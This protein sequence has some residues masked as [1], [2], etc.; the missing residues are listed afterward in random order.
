[1][2][3][4][5]FSCSLLEKNY[6]GRYL[7]RYQELYYLET[8]WTVRELTAPQLLEL[9]YLAVDANYAG[10]GAGTMLVQWALDLCEEEGCPAYVESTVEA[11]PFYEK[12]GFKAAGRIV[13]DF[14]EQTG[15]EEVVFYEEVGCIYVPKKAG[16]SE[17]IG[18]YVQASDWY[19]R[20]AREMEGLL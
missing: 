14:I 9:T 11:V 5:Q 20:Q 4:M 8:T 16:G 17:S 7:P 18:K 13:L 12:L 15:D 6:T 10:R 2:V 19:A 3:S 1:M